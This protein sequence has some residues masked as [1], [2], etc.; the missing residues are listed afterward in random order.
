MNLLK[1]RL[2]LAPNLIERRESS[3]RKHRAWFSGEH[4]HFEG[5]S[6]LDTSVVISFIHGLKDF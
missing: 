6:S 5:E 2:L 1:I 3:F 4:Y